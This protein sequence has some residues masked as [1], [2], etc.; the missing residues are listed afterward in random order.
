MSVFRTIGPLVYF[1]YV[2][3][4]TPVRKV[5]RKAFKAFKS[6]FSG[7]LAWKRLLKHSTPLKTSSNKY[8]LYEKHGTFDDALKDFYSVHPQN[9]MI[10]KDRI[11]ITH[12]IDQVRCINYNIISR[13]EHI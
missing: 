5:G 7:I 4:K 11:Q 8:R 12:R 1:Y 3:V 10:E 13:G 9:V 2:F 6:F